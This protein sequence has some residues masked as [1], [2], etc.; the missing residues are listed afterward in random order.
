MIALLNGNLVDVA[1]GEAVIDVNGV[2][3][4]VRVPATY[5]AKT[6]T[7]IKLFIDT[8]VLFHGNCSS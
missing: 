8:I 3:Y 7:S 4:A 6:G 5:F 1:N 2:G